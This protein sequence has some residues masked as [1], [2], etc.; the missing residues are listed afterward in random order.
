ME[1]LFEVMMRPSS[2]FS[3]KGVLRMAY[4]P[5]QLPHRG[6]QIKAL[7]MGLMPALEGEAPSNVFLYG[8]TGTGK[9]ATVRYVGKD[10]VEMGKAEDKRVE[11]V[12]INCEVVDTQY[13]VLARVA[14][15]FAEGDR[16]PFTGWPTDEVY[17]R[18]RQRLESAHCIAIIVLD[19]IDRLVSKGGDE[20]LYNLS[21]LDDELVH[22]RASIIGASNDLCFAD[23]LD[24]RVRSR[25]REEEI[26]FPPYNAQQLLDIL[27]QRA[28]LAFKP[29]VLQ[30][31]S[32][33]L[34]AALAAQEHGDAR[35]AL[36]LLKVAGEIADREGSPSVEDHHVMVAQSRI[37]LNRVV[38]VVR[39]LP[40]QSKIVLL[41]VI[42]GEESRIIPL[43]TGQIYSVYGELCVEAALTLLTQRRIT[44]LISE[45]DSLGIINARLVSKG[46]YGRTRE[47]R[48][49]VPINEIKHVILM[50]ELL[51]PLKSYSIGRQVTL[52]P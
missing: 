39:T 46:R 28:Q 25:L 13:R 47:I 44:D 36:S 52:Y 49:S 5:D 41:A 23:R 34:C 26:I 45:L 31:P 22:S 9:T 30:A 20:V 42:F 11:Y 14:N 32:L 50:D 4:T 3:D 8:K 16:V 24:P 35:R 48:L 2:V 7:A 10:L 37:E 15:H 17:D 38:E 12:Y 1:N 51:T 40:T 29:G 27:R 18:L 19:E 21:N 6:D 43:N 33:S